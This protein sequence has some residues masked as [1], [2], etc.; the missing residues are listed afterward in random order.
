MG[1]KNSGSIWKIFLI[2][3]LAALVGAGYVMFQNPQV[4]E[5]V[6]DAR[7][8]YENRDADLYQGINWT[9]GEIVKVL[10]G[11]W[12]YVKIQEG[13][14]YALRIRG[15]EAP[16][17]AVRLSDD[18]LKMG[19]EAKKFLE[20]LALKKPMRFQ[21]IDM[22]DQ[23]YG[24]GYIEINGESILFPMIRS[25]MARLNRQ[26]ITHFDNETLLDLFQTEREARKSEVGIWEPSL[27]IDWTVGDFSQTG[28][29]PQL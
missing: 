24:H 14:V 6:E 26:E 27:Q 3:G 22:S 15:L 1:K 28:K 19:Q 21:V 20:E 4:Q 16:T 7:W 18:T 25:G 5:K 8:I 10:D 11:N 9:D 12:V 29:T 13:F 2:I 23:R 17:L